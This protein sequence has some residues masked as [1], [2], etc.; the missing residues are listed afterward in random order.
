MLIPMILGIAVPMMMVKNYPDMSAELAEDTEKL[1]AS[2]NEFITAM[3]VIKMYHLTAEKFEQ[4]GTGR[5][6]DL[7]HFNA[8]GKL[9]P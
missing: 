5:G 1:N 7:R 4:Y 3:P 2:A 6:A 8:A 9:A